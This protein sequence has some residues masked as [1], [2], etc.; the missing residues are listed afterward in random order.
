M[1]VER[2]VELRLDAADRLAG[3][4]LG[5]GL[6]HADDRRQAGAERGARL[7][8][9]G[10]VELAEQL[11]PLRVAQDDVFAAGVGQLRQAPPRP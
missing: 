10:R 5:Q 7:Q 1:S 8:V 4:A 6:A 11:A 3:V 9:D 2:G